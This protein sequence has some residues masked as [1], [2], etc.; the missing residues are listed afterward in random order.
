MDLETPL[1]CANPS[2]KK[3]KEGA[4][5]SFL[6]GSASSAPPRTLSGVTQAALVSRTASR[7]E[8]ARQRSQGQ[9]SGLRARPPPSARLPWS[10]RWDR[11]D[12]AAPD[13]ARNGRATPRPRL[14]RGRSAASETGA[15]PGG[16]RLPVGAPRGW[17]PPGERVVGVRALGHLHPPSS[18]TACCPEGSHYPP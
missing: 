2:G 4:S 6:P 12:R 15:A 5:K 16:R 1:H 3:R 13:P 14:E 7:A 17:T 9:R 18:S 11:Q 8:P 10:G